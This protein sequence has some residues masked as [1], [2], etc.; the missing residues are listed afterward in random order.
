MGSSDMEREL[1]GKV[2]NYRTQCYASSTQQAYNTHRTTSFKFCELLGYFS[3]PISDVILCR[4]ATDLADRLS[5]NSI[6][7]YLNIIRILH[8]EV[9]LPNPLNNN[10]VLSTVMKCIVK[11]KGLSVKQ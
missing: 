7:Q 1:D 3:F 8:L 11:T 10:W 6:K 9:S 4:Y 2:T 5:Y